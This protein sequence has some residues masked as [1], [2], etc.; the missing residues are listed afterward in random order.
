MEEEDPKKLKMFLKDKQQKEAA[1][2]PKQRLITLLRDGVKLGY[3]LTGR[4]TS[5]FDDKTLKAFSPRLMS[6]VPEQ[7]DD[8]LVFVEI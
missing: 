7:E 2:D 3:S 6:V 4:N 1:N 5:E 8:D